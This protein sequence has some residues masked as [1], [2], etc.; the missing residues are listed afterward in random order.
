MKKKVWAIKLIF[1]LFVI[2]NISCKDKSNSINGHWHLITD[3]VTI[4][5]YYLTVDIKDSFVIVNKYDY[6]RKMVDKSKLF[7]QNDELYLRNN[8]FYDFKIDL[9]N[10]TLIFYNEIINFKWIR[11][12][13]TFEDKLNDMFCAVFLDIELDTLNVT[14]TIDSMN[15]EAH[16][17]INIGK[18]KRGF[19]NRKSYNE[20]FYIQCEDQICLIEDIEHYLKAEKEKASS[21]DDI[22]TVLIN[23]DKD[24]PAYLFKEVVEKVKMEKYVKRIYRSYINKEQQIIGLKEIY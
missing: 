13:N 16:C 2:L 18:A 9:V 8:L 4:E 11:F 22:F 21:N 14:R 5:G 12:E 10:D 1:I 6:S 24:V 20:E 23:V 3:S 17:I 19:K 15:T 7:C